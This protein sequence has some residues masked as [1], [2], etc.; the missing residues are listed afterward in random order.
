MESSEII[1]SSIPRIDA[2]EKVTGRAVYGP[3]LKLPGM[4][5]GKVLRSPL[6]HAQI[7]HVDPS[8]AERLPGVKAVVTGQDL[9]IRYGLV[10]QD[11]PPYCFDK[12]RYIGDPVAGVAAVDLDTAEEAL[13]SIPTG[14]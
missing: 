6:P 14:T 7:L 11:Q 10:I 13:D 1:G 2:F 8:R 5:Y 9:M 12:V 3:D 4:L